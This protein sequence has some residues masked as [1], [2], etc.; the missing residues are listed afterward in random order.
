MIRRI[1]IALALAALSTGASAQSLTAQQVATLRTSILSDPALAPKCVQFG[2]GPYDIAAAF[3]LPASPAYTIWRAAYTPDLKAAAIDN[4]ITQLDALTG[5]KREV[6][7]WWA[8]RQHDARLAST[9]AAMIDMTGSQTVLKAALQDGAKRPA[10]RF[11]RV[12]ATGTGSSAAP[13]TSTVDG[14]LAVS[15]V[16][17]AC[18]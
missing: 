12:F 8:N 13:G 9:Q 10:T 4:G 18:Q 17:R 1:F 11:E 14:A 5:S 7:L 3:N 2:D 16:L 15:D 6:L